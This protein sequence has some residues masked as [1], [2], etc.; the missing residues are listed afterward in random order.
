MCPILIEII[1]GGILVRVELE[2]AYAEAGKQDS[3]LFA[4]M[5]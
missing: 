5:R 2:I 3:E 1:L 4:N